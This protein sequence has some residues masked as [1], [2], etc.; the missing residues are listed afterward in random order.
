MKKLLVLL[1]AMMILLVGC[2]GDDA[3]SS[4][5]TPP[6]RPDAESTAPAAEEM[7][8]TLVNDTMYDFVEVYISPSASEDWGPNLLNGTM[9]SGNL[10]EMSPSEV[11]AAGEPYDILI[12]D[13]EMDTYLFYS[14]MLENM[15]GFSV[16]FA[17]GAPVVDAMNPNQEVTSTVQGELVFAE[18]AATGEGATAEAPDGSY[19]FTVY[20]ES[21]YDVYSIHIGLPTGAPEDDVDVLPMVLYAGE[22]YQIEGYASEGDMDVQDWTFFVTDTDGDT[23]AE[24]QIFNPWE[25]AYV[26]IIWD[27]SVGGY[28]CEFVY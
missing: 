26:D 15:G 11:A 22:S 4:A 21:A 28:V 27:S 10:S 5:V 9:A 14:V 2:G 24:Y 13:H 6:A 12:V 3:E 16:Y 19:S 20:N 8:V 18:E 17:D 25:V 7:S 1:L 23:S